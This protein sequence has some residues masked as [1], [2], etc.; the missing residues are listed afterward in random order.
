MTLTVE[1]IQ[2]AKTPREALLLLATAIDHLHARIDELDSDPFDAPLDWAGT[3]ASALIYDEALDDGRARIEGD[4]VIVQPVSPER[5]AARD[6]FAVGARLYEFYG[7]SLSPEDFVTAYRKGGPR[8]LYYTNRECVMQMPVSLRQR[9]VDDI[10]L[11]SPS[12]AAEIGAD[13]LKYSFDEAAREG[14]QIEQ[15]RL[16]RE[17]GDAA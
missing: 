11:D 6:D 12:E 1:Q 7:P 4:D 3:Q 9:L 16:N 10:L 13:I 5:E 14:E 17:L 8:W 2:Q 15:Q